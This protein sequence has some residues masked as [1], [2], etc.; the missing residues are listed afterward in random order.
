VLEA[1]AE[2]DGYND[3]I[4]DA[5]RGRQIWIDHGDGTVTRYC[6]LNGTAEG[7]VE[8]A[9]VTQG[10]LIAYVGE[11]G[12]PESLMEPGSQV[13]LHFELRVGFGFLGQGQD[14]TTTRA[15]YERAF[16]P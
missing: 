9:T 10:Q 12:T 15:L 14:A 4:V 11:S 13:H 6:H 1:L 3:D 7:V 16:S 5:F 2:Q 8:G